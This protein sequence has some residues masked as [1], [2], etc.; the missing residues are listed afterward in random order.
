[1]VAAI[2]Q[3]HASASL[4]TRR[5]REKEEEVEAE[6]KPIANEDGKNGKRW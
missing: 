1:M 2:E 6:K 5:E 3:R 4:W